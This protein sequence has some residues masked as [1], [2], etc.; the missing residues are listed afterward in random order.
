MHQPPCTRGKLHLRREKWCTSLPGPMLPA[1]ETRSVKNPLNEACKEAAGRG[2]TVW[3]WL[4][5]TLAH[6][7]SDPPLQ[8]APLIQHTADVYVQLL[9]NRCSVILDFTTSTCDKLNNLIVDYAHVRSYWK[10]MIDLD[11]RILFHLFCQYSGGC[12]VVIEGEWEP[13]ISKAGSLIE[14][15]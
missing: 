8:I 15:R 13:N 2:A 3:L 11:Y 1:I 5:T 9:A 10:E 4:Q 14:C 7:P 6:C 12:N